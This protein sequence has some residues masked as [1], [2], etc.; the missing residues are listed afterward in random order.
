M[1]QANIHGTKLVKPDL[2]ATNY[3]AP[4]KLIIDLTLPHYQ[5]G[6]GQDSK[7]KETLL[8]EQLARID[9]QSIMDQQQSGAN[10][11]NII[12]HT[13]EYRTQMPRP[14]LTKIYWLI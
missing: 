5:D 9:L 3:Y 6:H 10:T 13:A 7:V 11:A 2:C 1:S 14:S 8:F 4:K 12:K